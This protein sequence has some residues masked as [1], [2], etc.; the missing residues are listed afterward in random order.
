MKGTACVKIMT[1]LGLALLLTSFS[2]CI[3][4]TSD[5]V[6]ME[7][8]LVADKMVL[9]N[10]VGKV[11]ITGDTGRIAY[12]HVQAEKRA[13]TFSLFGLANP[14]NYIDHIE[15]YQHLE[16]GEAHIGVSVRSLPLLERLF[17]KVSPRVAF[18]LN[19]P[20]ALNTNVKVDVGNVAIHNLVGHVD[21]T[22]N[23]GE[24]TVSSTLGVFGN[25]SFNVNIGSLDMRLPADMPVRYDLETSIGGIESA[26]LNANVE[27][28]LLGAR[29]AGS[30][31]TPNM[32]PSFVE[33]RVNVGNINFYG[34]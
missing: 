18:T 17:V 27:R 31:G 19:T 29:A 14:N 30:Q 13:Q 25:Q 2:G 34:E 26:G 3:R 4:R 22:S 20:V 21:A 7:T 33:G 28:R 1:I 12:T 11:D 16:D 24:I 9:S 23:V 15:V 8:E 5:A 10:S 6:L 32:T